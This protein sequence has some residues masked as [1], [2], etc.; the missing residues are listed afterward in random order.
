[1]KK[2]INQKL[3][4]TETA[5]KVGEW[6]NGYGQGDFRWARE[7]LYMKRTGEYFL[8]GEGGG[9]SQYAGHYG[10]SSG[11]GESIE[12]LTY[13]Q[14]RDWAEARLEADEYMRLFEIVP[15]EEYQGTVQVQAVVSAEAR[16]RLDIYRKKRG[17]TL[18]EALNG[19]LL[20][21]E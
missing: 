16:Q 13:S 7:E 17:E 1:M 5:T 4:D 14:A 15:E 21:L 9:L 8:Y 2:I 19:I 12:P 20:A 10:D 18:S 6:S 3:Y 11:D